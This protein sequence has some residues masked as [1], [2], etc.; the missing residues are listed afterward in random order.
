M[1]SQGFYKLVGGLFYKILENSGTFWKHLELFS[2][3]CW[4]VE[5]T[6]AFQLGA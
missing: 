6:Y 3:N 5:A 1:G 4:R 2:N